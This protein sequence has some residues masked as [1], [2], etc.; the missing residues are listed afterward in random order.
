MCRCQPLLPRACLHFETSVSHKTAR[1]GAVSVFLWRWSHSSERAIIGGLA[2]SAC[3]RAGQQ[4]RGSGSKQGRCATPVGSSRRRNSW[5]GPVRQSA[6]ARIYDALV[7]T[8][9]S[10]WPA[11]CSDWKDKLS[12]HM[13]FVGKQAHRATT[14]QQA[15]SHPAPALAAKLFHPASACQLSS[16]SLRQPAHVHMLQ[17][18]RLNAHTS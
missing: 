4:P 12:G 18:S 3:L 5:S 11:S 8:E 6:T 15:E 17:S 13:R 14:R 16:R 2:K 1:S 10:I 7:P 9:C